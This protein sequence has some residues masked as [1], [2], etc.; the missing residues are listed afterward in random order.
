MRHALLLISIAIGLLLGATLWAMRPVSD[1]GTPVAAPLTGQTEQRKVEVN[2]ASRD[3]LLRV[4]G[5]TPR[6]ADRLIQ[7]RPYRKLDDLVSRKVLGK[8]EFAIIRDH[9]AVRRAP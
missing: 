8:K 9:I 6:V 7:H 1:A 3:E 2:H 4:P 5:M